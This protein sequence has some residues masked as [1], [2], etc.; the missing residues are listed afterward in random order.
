[1]AIDPGDSGCTD[2]LSGAIYGA[3]S[4]DPASGFSSPMTE[5]QTATIKAECYRWAQSIAAAVNAEVGGDVPYAV[6]QESLASAFGPVSP[7]PYAPASGYPSFS[8]NVPSERDYLAEVTFEFI[9]SN[10][11]DLA[12]FALFV[13]GGP[14]AGHPVYSANYQ[15]STDQLGARIRFTF[16][17]RIPGLAAG[18]HTLSIGWGTQA[19]GYLATDTSCFV[20]YSVWG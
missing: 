10:A 12:E 11:A 17:T 15:F 1:M 20:T 19:S 5:T 14:V 4:A 7:G 6:Q 8:I 9:P 13:D 18:A 2:G 16:L 3:W